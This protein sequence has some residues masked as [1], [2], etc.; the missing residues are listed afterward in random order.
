MLVCHN[1]LKEYSLGNHRLANVEPR[2][3]QGDKVTFL[4]EG[5]GLGLMCGDYIAFNYQ[6]ANSIDGHGN[7]IFRI[8]RIKKVAYKQITGRHDHFCAI[9]ESKTLTEGLLAELNYAHLTMVRFYKDPDAKEGQGPASDSRDFG[10]VIFTDL[11]E[12]TKFREMLEED[13]AKKGGK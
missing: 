6:S 5:Y 8:G 11:L 12:K 13:W 7:N 2:V 4:I 1:F 10:Y 9:V 3:K